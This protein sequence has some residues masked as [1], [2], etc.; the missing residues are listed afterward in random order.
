MK[1][2]LASTAVALTLA[3]PVYADGHMASE[4]AFSSTYQTGQYR[5]TDLIGATLWQTENA[6]DMDGSMVNPEE[7]EWNRVGEINDLIITGDGSVDHIVA[8]VGGFLGMGQ[9][10]ISIKMSD[11]K[12]VSD[13]EEADE[14][15]AVLTT[16]PAALQEAPEYEARPMQNDM[17]EAAVTDDEAAVTNDEAAA[18]NDEAA[19]TNEEVAVTNPDAT[20]GEPVNADIA[21]RDAVITTEDLT[22]A[23]VY[24]S[25]DENVGEVSQLILGDDGTSIKQAVIDVGGFLG[26]GE[27]P[28]ALDLDKLNVVMGENGGIERVTVNATREE[29]DAMQMWEK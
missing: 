23:V 8:A 25:A 7:L 16:T 1:S 28:V 24:S 6:V 12:I 29:L 9:E 14:W 19:V 13:G 5:G 11:L 20:L 18:T 22:G 21:M 10:L 17:D 3:A 15:Y 4:E 27:K 26:L 2:L